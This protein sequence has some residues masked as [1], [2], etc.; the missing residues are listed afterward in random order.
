MLLQLQ[1]KTQ[2]L[3]GLTS[4]FAVWDILCDDGCNG[5]AWADNQGKTATITAANSAPR[6]LP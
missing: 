6:F 2:R 4:C 3:A 5:W 1:N